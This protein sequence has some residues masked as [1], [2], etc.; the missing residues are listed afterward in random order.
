M[1]TRTTTAPPHPATAAARPRL[2]PIPDPP[3][4]IDMVTQLPHTARIHTIL[5]DWF[6]QRPDVLVSDVLVSG[7]GYLCRTA[8]EARRSPHPD[9]MVALDLSIPPLEIEMSNGYT[10]SEIGKP[11]DFVLEVASESTGLRD[12]TIKR[13][14]YANLG[15]GE[16]WRFDRTGG[17]FHDAALAG[18]RL[19]P[20]G[21]YEPMRLDEQ[22]NGSIRGY[23]PALRLELRWESNWLYF[24]DPATRTY[25]PDLTEAKAQRDAVAHLRDV[26]VRRADAEA[27]ARRLAEDRVD[28]ET[29]ARQTAEDRVDA[30]AAARQRAEDQVDVE[31]AARR[32]AEQR[33][34]TEAAARQI[35]E[36]RLRQLEAEL[37]RLRSAN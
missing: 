32:L 34:S 18:D 22:S 21:R 19:T 1:T 11:P 31:A 37:Q 3:R 28:A 36:Q 35:A 24:W 8:G 20:E 29:A 7:K 15:V 13:E 4:D 14:Q 16:Y 9:C 17:L 23:S 25:L 2:T 12:C 27:A 33:A 26:A 10:I 30:E 5:A 6:R